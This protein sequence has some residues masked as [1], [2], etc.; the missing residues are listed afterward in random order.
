M[1]HDV[2]SVTLVTSV[3]S[4]TSVTSVASA[5]SVTSLR[6]LHQLHPLGLL[7]Q[8]HP[9]RQAALTTALATADHIGSC[10]PFGGNGPD[11]IAKAKEMGVMASSMVEAERRLNEISKA[12]ATGRYTPVT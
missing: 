10:S 12:R 11:A 7:H 1:P 8:L 6:L 3:G 2:T 4:V 5:T 9:L